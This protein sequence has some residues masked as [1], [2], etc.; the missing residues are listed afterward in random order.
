MCQA[1]EIQVDI[2]LLCSQLNFHLK[3]NPKG[4]SRPFTALLLTIRTAYNINGIL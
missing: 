3:V 2:D 1:F 4:Q